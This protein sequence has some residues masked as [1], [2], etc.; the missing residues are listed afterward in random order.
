MSETLGSIQI[1]LRLEKKQFDQQL[2]NLKALKGT[3]IAFGATLDTRLLR[4]QINNLSQLN[5]TISA[6]VVVKNLNQVEAQLKTLTRDRAI[7][8]GATL[9]DR[10]LS[11]QLESL[12]QSRIIRLQSALINA[13][14]IE[15]QIKTLTRDRS[16]KIGVEFDT[17]GIEQKLAKFSDKTFKVTAQVDD[18]QLT[19]LNKH[20]D[21]K[22]KHFTQVNNYF[23]SSPLKP[24]VDLSGLTS[25]EEAMKRLTRSA[26]GTGLRVPVTFQANS[27]AV[28]A[29]R[30][31]IGTIAIP[32]R[33]QYS[34]I[35]PGVPLKQDIQFGTS[36]LNDLEKGITDS[37]QRGFKSAQGKG[38]FGSIGNIV[39]APLRNI[40]RGFQEGIGSTYAQKLTSGTIQN[41]EKEL[42][43][44]LTRIGEKVGEQFT[45][46]GK[47]A[48]NR[49]LVKI[50]V[51]EGIEGLKPRLKEIG[52]FFNDIIDEKVLGRKFSV[53]ET[54]IGKLIDDLLTMKGL[55]SQVANV[56]AIGRSVVDLAATPVEGIRERKKQVLKTSYEKAQARAEQINAPTLDNPD[57]IVFGIGGFAGTRGKSSPAVAERM[58]ILTGTKNPVVPIPNT[59]SDLPY[60]VGEG[61]LKFFGSAIAKLVG[62]GIK[63]YNED[64]IEA[65]AQAIA[66]QKA[67]PK[68]KLNFAGY[69]QGGYIAQ[70]AVEILGQGKIKSRGVGIGTPRFGLNSTLE[71]GEYQSILGEQDVLLKPTKLSNAKDYKTFKDGGKGHRSSSY[72]GTP[73]TQQAFLKQLGIKRELSPE[74]Q[75]PVPYEFAGFEQELN[76]SAEDIGKVLSNPKQAAFFKKTGLY[77]A[78]LA[79]LQ[80]HRAKVAQFM[81]QAVGEDITRLEAYDEALAEAE[82]VVKTV[83]GVKSP[84]APAIKANRDKAPE[85]ASPDLSSSIASKSKPIL[86]TLQDLKEPAETPKIG[87]KEQLSQQLGGYNVD[88]LKEISRVAGLKTA[89]NKQVLLDQLMGAD[90]SDVE[91]ALR[92]VTP[93]IERGARGGQK[94][95]KVDQTDG[96]KRILQIAQESEK[97]VNDALRLLQSAE[98]QR[99]NDIIAAATNEINETTATLERLTGKVVSSETR[100]AAGRQKGR[101]SGLKKEFTK[102]PKSADDVE[103]AR[104]NPVARVGGFVRSEQGKALLEDLAVNSVGF[105]ASQVGNQFGVVPGLAGDLGGALVARNAIATG[106]A[107]FSAFR[108]LRQQ[109]QFKQASLLGKAKLLGN[110]TKLNLQSEM[111][112]RSLGSNLTGD[113]TGFAIGN[114]FANAANAGLDAISG[115]VPGAGILRAVPFKG[116]L[117]AGLTVPK[118]TKIRET[119]S[120]GINVAKASDPEAPILQYLKQVD[121]YV[122]ET[123]KAIEKRKGSDRKKLEDEL[124]KYLQEQLKYTEQFNSSKFGSVVQSQATKTQTN[125][126]AVSTKLSPDSTKAKQ[127]LNG[128]QKDIQLNMQQTYQLLVREAAKLSG[129]AL[130]P[131]DIP[132]LVIDDGKLKSIGARALYS[133]KNNQIILTQEV[134]NL[135]NGTLSDLEKNQKHIADIVHEARHSFQFDFGRSTIAKQAIGLTQPGVP[136][137]N[138]GETPRDVQYNA[139][140]SAQIANQ[141]AGGILPKRFQSVIART[142]ADAYAF[143][144]RTP[145]VVGNVA[146]QLRA[147]IAP[148][149]VEASE[150]NE[151]LVNFFRGVFKFGR[152]PV[153]TTKNA[154][155]NIFNQLQASALGG[156][157][158]AAKAQDPTGFA[159]LLSGISIPQPLQQIAGIFRAS[160]TAADSFRGGIK[161]LV[162]TIDTAIPGAGKLLT[163]IKGLAAGFI[164][165][166]LVSAGIQQLQQFSQGAIK[167]AIDV[168]RLKTALDFASNGKGAEKLA[169][170]TKESNRLGVDAQSAQESY[171][172]TVAGAKG[173]GLEGSVD[174]LFTGVLSASTTLGL[175]KDQQGRALLALQQIINKGKLSAE[176]L[177]QLAEAGVAGAYGKAADSLGVS[178]AELSKRLESG[179]VS[180]KEFIPK[181]GQR[182][183]AEYGAS[184]E[185][186]SQNAQSSLFRL[187]NSTRQSQI[188]TG[189]A[190]SPAL[191]VGATA[192]AKS[193]DFLNEKGGA[194]VQMFGILAA[195]IAVPL[196]TPL[197]SAILSTGALKAGVG[198]LTAG[199]GAL[200]AQLG[201][202]AL[203]FAIVTAAAELVRSTIEIFSLDERG[204]GFKKMA[205]QGEAGLERIAK[206][207]RIAKGAINDID[208]KKPST[209]KGFDLSFG[210][211]K[212]SGLEDAGISLKTDDLIKGARKNPSLSLLTGGVDIGQATTVEELQQQKAQIEKSN[213]LDATRK[214]VNQVYSGKI[215]A[216]D[217]KGRVGEADINDSL[218]QVSTIDSQVTDLQNKRNLLASQPRAN[219]TELAKIDEQVKALSEQRNKVVQPVVELQGTIQGKLNEAKAQLAN[220]TGLT[221]QDK[222]DLQNEIDGLEKAQSKLT[223]MQNRAGTAADK[224]G[225]FKTALSKMNDELERV[226]R[227]A[228]LKF[229]LTTS[230]NLKSQLENR[231]T[232][233]SASLNA[234][235][236]AA[237]TDSTRA[238]DELSGNQ[239]V[240]DKLKEK[241]QSPDVQQQLAG[242][243]IG[244]TGKTISLDSTVKELEDAKAGKNEDQK[245]VLQDLVDYR[246]AVDAQPEKQSAVYK[247]KLNVADTKEKKFLSN[248]AFEAQERE[249]SSKQSI[250]KDQIS[251]IEKQKTKSISEEDVAIESAK[252]S[253]KQNDRELLSANQ[254]LQELTAA[255]NKGEISA[256]TFAQKRIELES[257]VSDLTVKKAQDELAVREAVNRKII[258]GFERRNKIASAKIDA[259]SSDAIANIRTTQ[260]NGGMV[261]EGGQAEIAKVE[262]SATEQRMALKRQELAGVKNLRSQRVISEKE[263]SD[264]ELAIEAELRDGRSKLIDL[265][266]QKVLRGIQNEVDAQKRASDAKIS[267]IE[268]EKTEIDGVIAKLE[269]KQKLVDLDLQLSQATSGLRQSQLKGSIDRVDEA[270]GLQK[271]LKGEGLGNNT[272]QVAQSQLR[273]LG[274]NPGTNEVDMLRTKQA[275]QAEIDAERIA[276]LQQQQVLEQESLKLGFEKEK[277]SAALNL[278][279]RE[280][281][282]LKAQQNIFEAKGALL[283]AQKTG[284]ANEVSNA[285][286]QLNL[287]NQILDNTQKQF[288]VEKMRAGAIDQSIQKQQ[289]LNDL[290]QAQTRSELQG[291]TDKNRR[292][293]ELE[294]AQTQDQSGIGGFG[295]GGSSG[296]SSGGGGRVVRSLNLFGADI[297]ANRRGTESVD[298]AI[299]NTLGDHKDQEGAVLNAIRGLQGRDKDFALLAAQDRGYSE[300]VSVVNQLD[301][302]RQ[303]K[304]G[305]QVESAISRASFANDNSTIVAALKDLGDRL[306]KNMSRPNLSFTGTDPVDTY[307]DYSNRQSSS[308]L[309]GL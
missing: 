84:V 299:K 79:T 142:E 169:F 262:E 133:I 72:L 225:D 257:K 41:L 210:L 224:V 163:N 48:G 158:S 12:T 100:V 21:L 209:S 192:L 125:L 173:S 141:Q 88:V 219:K 296:G 160:S 75:T 270:G 212:A 19:A 45:K 306:E 287:N 73:D 199:L 176:E 44:S 30:S 231:G 137:A 303:G 87:N 275:L 266:T 188:Q 235:V 65:A 288:D 13:N 3:Q 109:D 64:A 308:T 183:Q 6:T 238:Q 68:A 232:D 218:Q 253:G 24:T 215:S 166:Q 196:L 74:L 195:T 233:K 7:N 43:V 179:S 71:N 111:M 126:A 140:R 268:K 227:N 189:Q 178:G 96:E 221:D 291:E 57:S 103:L 144:T 223:Q 98:G 86:D 165:F 107:G 105:A 51:E 49:V 143:E 114:G 53:L 241:A 80:Q 309:R 26:L 251:L 278:L 198:L 119:L 116:A 197:A 129:V 256:E 302:L 66:Y 117:A 167:A 55:S 298:Y 240:L 151:K 203:Q 94:I 46:V 300:V 211:A 89:G 152:N 147:G 305:M 120:G 247:A 28:A 40:S 136:L 205:D 250:G 154:V 47:F 277:Q 186:A 31:Q 77:K 293:R 181:F 237:N 170:I 269:V 139:L 164:G 200:K 18:S 127:A 222:K 191:T 85:Q 248:N 112:Q 272:R 283:K 155:G 185:D 56:G 90:S 20:L 130:N 206:A 279:E 50:G 58:Q 149:A 52:G 118:I 157:G 138:F 229:N 81:D 134:A 187:G 273:E 294:L 204:Q 32:V 150:P 252:L 286:A 83:F 161:G 258:E 156:L 220:N 162:N 175:T 148:A 33:F 260:L 267:A 271:Q 290:K 243:T 106:K 168:D 207:A 153:A 172:Q 122:A 228:D 1:E 97:R 132:K 9:D 265:Q 25:A 113:L 249:L 101:L 38:L 131:R 124:K 217:A 95:K 201:T 70:E 284:D 54:Q 301:S 242:M 246:K 304:R 226:K 69:S 145:K 60:N 234:A 62:N 230:G 261:G 146:A 239:A 289:Q 22:Q 99:R 2:E 208:T 108:G 295:G 244:S 276:A 171:A 29:L 193:L 36:G 39:T 115:V 15:S 216:T 63:G 280:N 174:P 184:A 128:A 78:Q 14:A 180:A 135:L 274:F 8:L 37:V 17:Q 16:I 34:E 104:V 259:G 190:F 42:G 82:S 236:D 91:N 214:L 23:K 11:A 282:V 5:P 76:A 121:A 92:A 123:S 297:E 67:N 245:K 194:L 202:V 254:Q 307:A 4:T 59:A 264:R 255:Y 10:K 177:N 292:S 285:Q 61:K 159:K 182:L 35:K 263:A 213:S 102:P 110:Q 93:L 27:G 281:A